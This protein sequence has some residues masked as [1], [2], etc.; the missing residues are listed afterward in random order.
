MSS[1]SSAVHAITYLIALFM[2]V[3]TEFLQA[4]IV[5]EKVLSCDPIKLKKVKKAEIFGLSQE[6][7]LPIRLALKR[8]LA[9]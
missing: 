5:R 9:D 7:T 4:R 1:F 8:S 6:S 2:H 3:M